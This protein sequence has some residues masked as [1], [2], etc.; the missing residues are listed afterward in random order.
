ML[1]KYVSVSLAMFSGS[2]QLDRMTQP[3][4]MASSRS[5]FVSMY[6]IVYVSTQSL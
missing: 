2:I 4:S 6:V 1:V 5:V 3:A